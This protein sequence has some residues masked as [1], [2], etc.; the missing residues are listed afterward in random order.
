MFK[1]NFEWVNYGTNI[2]HYDKIN[3][4]QMAE[5]VFFNIKTT[6]RKQ[7][8]QLLTEKQL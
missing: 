7:I 1:T 6:K 2:K 5:F 8:K 3:N 4:R